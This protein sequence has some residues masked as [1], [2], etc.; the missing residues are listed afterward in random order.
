MLRYSLYLSFQPDYQI[1]TVGWEGGA[2]FS[3]PTLKKYENA[4]SNSRVVG[5]LIAEL[6]DS[7]SQTLSYPMSRVHCIGHSLG[8]HACGFAGK[9][10]TGNMTMGRITGNLCSR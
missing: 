10:L 5:A 4:V 1:I 3:V 8:A 7:L 2:K 6:M 9:L